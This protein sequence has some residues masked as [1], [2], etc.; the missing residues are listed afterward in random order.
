MSTTVLSTP[1]TA[2]P[3]SGLPP[4]LLSPL[5]VAE[6]K[7]RLQPGTRYHL[8]HRTNAAG[9][10]A[11]RGDHLP[12]REVI[13]VQSTQVHSHVIGGESTWL[14]FPV[15]KNSDT[16]HATPDG[17]QFLL[18][19]NGNTLRFAWGDAPEG[20]AV[21]RPAAPQSQSKSSGG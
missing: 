7:R 17:F 18:A 9:P 10:V 14:T 16:L 15:F 13:K 6:L 19:G 8:T 5:S 4:A 2:P 11:F 12:G 1:H 21:N 20:A 3:V